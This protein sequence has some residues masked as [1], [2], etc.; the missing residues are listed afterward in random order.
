MVLSEEMD[1]YVANLVE[2]GDYTSVNDVVQ[3]AFAKLKRE[4]DEKF[5]ALRAAI[6]EEFEGE[7]VDGSVSE[8]FDRVRQR[9]GLPPRKRTH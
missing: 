9:A 7:L 8:L 3:H 2:D 1:T 6:N 4:D 5:A